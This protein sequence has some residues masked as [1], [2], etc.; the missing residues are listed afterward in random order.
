MK[1]LILLTVYFISPIPL[2]GALWH[3]DPDKY[4]DPMFAA[5][6]ILGGCAYTWLS[7]EFIL[8]A[9]IRL[10]EREFG[11]DMF[12]RFHAIMAI[13]C[14]AF[15]IAHKIIEESLVGE[16]PAGTVGNISMIAFAAVCFLALCFMSDSFMMRFKPF[17]RLRKFTGRFKPGRYGFQVAL[18]NISAAALTVMCIHVMMT[19]SAQSSHAV[20]AAYL[21]YFVLGA[22]VYVY[23]RLLRRLIAMHHPFTITEVIRH[24]PVMTTLVLVPD[25]G[26]VFHY[27]PGQFGFLRIKAQGI[28]AE[29]HPFSLT[30]QP[31]DR[32]RLTVMI[33]SLG[34]YTSA[35]TNL[36]PGAKAF[37][38]A[39][40]GRF[41]HLLHPHEKGTVLL[42]GGIG[43]TPA[44]SMLRYLHEHDRQRAVI[45]I[46]GADYKGDL[47][48]PDEFAAMQRDM[49]RFRMNPVLFREKNWKGETGI[50]DEEKISRILGAEG[51]RID[52]MGFYICGPAPMLRRILHGL[53]LLHVKKKMIHHERFSI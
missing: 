1:K 27:L 15:V 22:G 21:V 12:Y 53:K 26:K 30:S 6:M 50:I 25:N 11:L 49:P 42:V 5:A 2:C 40:Y 45:M 14:V 52:E 13:V 7:A 16:I 31:G 36:E 18:H 47:I 35:I 24:S 3:A 41:S 28:A 8:I 33:K 19:S 37:M 17:F 34:D 4:S 44:L 51:H 48:L 43:I 46:W 39:P 32:T 20:K 29:E 9:R 38:D 10:I 23:H